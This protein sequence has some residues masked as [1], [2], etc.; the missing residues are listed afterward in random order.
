[1]WTLKITLRP[2]SEQRE[3]DPEP[4]FDDASRIIS[5]LIEYWGILPEDMVET[6]DWTETN[7]EVRDIEVLDALIDPMNWIMM[8]TIPRKIELIRDE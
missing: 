6:A 1:M 5:H 7:V 8:H 4:V 2:Y 3:I